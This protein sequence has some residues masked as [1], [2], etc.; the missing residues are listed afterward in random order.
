MDIKSKNNNKQVIIINIAIIIIL[1]MASI[2]TFQ[3]YSKI[4]NTLRL[5]D[6]DVYA[7]YIS[8][9]DVIMRY[10][11][12]LYKEYMMSKNPDIQNESDIFIESYTTDEGYNEVIKKDINGLLNS[13]QKDLSKNYK[14]FD[15]AILNEDYTIFKTNADEETR[16]IIENERFEELEDAYQWYSVIEYNDKGLQTIFRVPLKSESYG[17]YPYSNG[18]K[19]DS[20]LINYYDY[21]NSVN[22]EL[23]NYN[24]DDIDQGESSYIHQDVTLKPINNIKFFYG[25]KKDLEHEDIISDV[26]KDELNRY[27]KNGDILAYVIGVII[28]IAIV[29]SLIIPY[30]LS[31]DTIIGKSLFKIPLELN[32]VMGSIGSLIIVSIFSISM[33]TTI[34]GHLNEFL[35]SFKLEQD[36]TN[37]LIIVANIAFLMFL[38]SFILAGITYIKHIFKRGIIKSFKEDT[39]LGKLIR[40]TKKRTGNLMKYLSNID[41]TDK[42]DKIVFKIVAINF[43]I[44]SG[45]SVIWF[46]GIGASFIYSIVIFVLLRRYTS[47]I[48]EKYRI[49]LI[50]TNEIAE[51]NLDVQID[52]DLGLF[53]PFKR[54]L[55]KI[56]IGF[57]KA[58]QKEVKSER[59][60]SELISNVSH[61]LKTPLTSIITYTDL[62]KH[63]NPSEEERG[64]YIETI[65]KKSKRLKLL[66]EDLFEMS[67]ANSGDIRLNIEPVDIVGLIRQTEVELEDKI[68]ESK[69]TLRNNFPKDKVILNLDGEKTYRIFENLLSNASKYSMANSRVY[70]DV[71]DFEDN[72]EVLIKN[73]S[74]V[75]MKFSEEEI[76]DRFV[77]GDLSRNTD[78]SGIGLAI[79][80]SFI[81]IQKGSFNIEIDGD[82]FKVRITFPK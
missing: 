21:K 75:E 20:Y 73:T 30:K 6:E 36:F 3:Q 80:K 60:K 16:T 59:M 43:V 27:S 1:L 54:E 44:L 56:Q 13:W 48:K 62:L 42:S 40:W 52:E 11:T 10:N 22:V 66:I 33:F 81:E 71:K 49:L 39:L 23:N 15:Y 55:V 8:Q 67:K 9:S 37:K 18:K 34:T 70:I 76:T 47:E 50:K 82:L 57:K 61:D 5:E 25:I 78:G 41:L 2:G 14:N 24:N 79:V 38:Y 53:N 28:S 58:V 63:G 72:V 69:L 64:Q 65:E 74:V 68:E 45:I 35:L 77:R 4:K 12:M 51:G 19:L 26:I 7:N 17:N 31:K 46:F 29:V 32:A